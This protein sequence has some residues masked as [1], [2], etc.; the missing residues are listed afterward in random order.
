LLLEHLALVESVIRGVARRY[1]IPPDEAEELAG[2]VRLKLVDNDY[3]VLRRFEGRSA[4]NTYLTTIVTRCYLDTRTQ[5]WGKWR[6]SAQARRLGP[7]AILLERMLTRDR[8]T[9]D[10]ACE[11]LRVNHHVTES[12]ERLQTLAAQLPDR[13]SRRFVTDNGLAELPASRSPELDATLNM[14]VLPVVDRFGAAMSAALSQLT[15]EDRL[16]LRMRFQDG[17]PVA[18]IARMLGTPQKPLYRHLDRVMLLLRRELEVR[19]VDRTQVDAICAAGEFSLPSLAQ[20]GP[21]L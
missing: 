6:P 8:W 16:L 7:V 3:Q 9:L 13:P 12:R 5:K 14:D 17:L 18:D 19:G 10:E 1:R 21:T 4:L 2:V 15:D 20:H 11:M